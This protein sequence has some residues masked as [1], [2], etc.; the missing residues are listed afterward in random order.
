MLSLV[1]LD[2]EAL[3]AEVL[4]HKEGAKEETSESCPQEQDGSSVIGDAP[5]AAPG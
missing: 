1:V 5:A 4:L 2:E 3:L